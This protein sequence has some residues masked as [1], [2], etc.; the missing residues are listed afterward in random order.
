M[1]LDA[2]A[3]IVGSKPPI[4]TIT[5]NGWTAELSIVDRENDDDTISKVVKIVDW[6]GGVL[7]KPEINV[8]I[9]EDGFVSNIEDAVD[10]RGG[11]GITPNITVG[12]VTTGNAGTSV[13][14]TKTGTLLN[15][16]FNFTIPRGDIGNT[17]DIEIGSVIASASGSDPQASF[18]GTPENP[19][20]NLVLPR[21]LQGLQG[22]PG[23]AIKG[24]A[25]PSSNPPLD[26]TNIQVWYATEAGTYTNFGGVIVEPSSFAIIYSNGGGVWDITQTPL[27][28]ELTEPIRN[29]S[30]NTPILTFGDNLVDIAEIQEDKAL[31]GGT[32][33]IVT[34]TDSTLSN[35]IAVKAETTYVY[36][37]NF[38]SRIRFEDKEHNLISGLA[39]GGDP[40][41]FTT[42]VGCAFVVVVMKN[43]G[44]PDSNYLLV[45]LRE[46]WMDKQQLD[47]ESREKIDWIVSVIPGKNK[48]NKNGELQLNKALNGST[49]TI[50]TVF[51]SVL[52]EFIPV[53]PNT[54]YTYQGNEFS[55]VGFYDEDKVLISGLGEAGDPRSFTTP[56]NC[57]FVV[58]PMKNPGEPTSNYDLVQL[59][60]GGTA[61]AYEE[62]R[63]VIP[64]ANIEDGGLSSVEGEWWKGIQFLFFGDSITF[65]NQYQQT[66]NDIL[67]I[68]WINN[69]VP[70]SCV[71]PGYG[72]DPGTGIE[73]SLYE[74]VGSVTFQNPDVIAIFGG[75][76][77]YGYEAPL[78]TIADTGTTTFYGAY[79]NMLS[80]LQEDNPEAIIFT[81]TPIYGNLGTGVSA[82]KTDLEVWEDRRLYVD[83]IIQLSAEYSIPCYDA[84]RNSGIGVNNFNSW[85]FDKIHPNTAGM[86][87]LG[88]VFSSFI[89]SIG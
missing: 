32:G 59:E 3:Q 42:P 13:I 22:V 83:A 10:I 15:P 86:V 38:Y 9:G 89:K 62:Y 6:F 28:E 30:K 60:K 44:E 79:R 87:K 20:L 61:T 88:R 71:T 56:S 31:N 29:L 49:G 14:I 5:Q 21:G 1:S 63:F 25:I 77:D 75:T 35:P 73:P 18:T 70:G 48:V 11:I 78:G 74:R 50:V 58:V 2:Q 12:T 53:D 54:A 41:V 82:G 51:D 27:D 46:R 16:I 80:E 40:H 34:L 37:G 72:N 4:I 33:I 47:A 23:S 65:Y 19:I 68:D 36:E 84:F 43:P 24:T 7:K 76:N 57:A 17:P 69:A 55:R 45:S 85:L 8:F 67:G 52:S 81:I 64:K 39:E 26:A 66:I